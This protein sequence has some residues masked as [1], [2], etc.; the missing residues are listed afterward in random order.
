MMQA[1]I[2]FLYLPDAISLAIIV[3]A[4]FLLRH[5][6]IEHF[7]QELLKIRNKLILFCSDAKFPLDH[8]ACLHIHN[9]ITLLGRIVERISPANLFFIRRVCKDALRNDPRFV[10]PFA[11]DRLGE[12]LDKIANRRMAEKLLITQLEINLTLGSFYLLG[13]LSGWMISLRGLYK[14]AFRK[15]A[16]HPKRKLDKRMDMAERLISRI[17]YETFVLI[18][19]KTRAA[20]PPILIPTA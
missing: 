20:E 2:P 1:Q 12:K 13:S 11:P 6:A 9:E 17:G 18:F 7:R 14:V 16:G 3:I 10:L 4:L 5:L 15:L 8:P 19:M